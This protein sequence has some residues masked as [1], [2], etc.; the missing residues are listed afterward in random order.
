MTG[1]TMRLRTGMSAGLLATLVACA[2]AANPAPPSASAPPAPPAQGS[3]DPL[4]SMI[5]A[6][7]QEG[8]LELV[9][10]ESQSGGREAANRW[11]QGFNNYYGLNLP[12]RYTQGPSVQELAVRIVQEYQSNR[13]AVSDVMINTEVTALDMAQANALESVDWLSWA[14]NIRNAKLLA[15]GGVAVEFTTQT[16]G[17]TYATARLSGDAV[18]RTLQDLLKPEYKGRLASTPYA[19]YFDSLASRELWGEQRVIEYTTRL[20]EQITGLVRCGE[21]ERLQSG[22]FDILAVDC[23]NSNASRAQAAGAPIGQVIASDAP[24]IAIRYMSIPRNARHPNAAKLWVNYILSREGQDILYQTD[25][26]DHYLVDGSKSASRMAELR[27]TG[28]TF[29]TIDV[30]FVQRN[31]MQSLARTLSDVQRILQKQ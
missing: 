17:M 24:L 11:T 22:E 13:P 31:D 6:A 20:A 9:W 19:A 15:P 8:E 7:R 21:T 27:A 5:D 1:L 16:P 10:A 18:P 25:F 12:I 3:G 26:V 14:P 23:G 2:Q 29:T 4:Q 28:V 30:D